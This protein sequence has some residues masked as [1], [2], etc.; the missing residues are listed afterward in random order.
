[1]EGEVGCFGQ[2]IALGG[3]DDLAIHVEL[4]ATEV[5]QDQVWPQSEALRELV[6]E[7]TRQLQGAAVLHRGAV[8][9]VG[10]RGR[11]QVAAVTTTEDQRR[12][13]DHVLD[14]AIRAPS[15]AADGGLGGDC[16]G[17]RERGERAAQRRGRHGRSRAQ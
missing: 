1:V 17:Q 11:L 4:A 16:R 8:G 9:A 3:L 12:I 13:A 15:G 10:D 14:G 6:G 7:L 2:R 5:A